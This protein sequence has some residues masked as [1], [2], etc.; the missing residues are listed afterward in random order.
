MAI[1]CIGI[2]KSEVEHL[3]VGVYKYTEKKQMMEKVYIVIQQLLLFYNN[4]QRTHT[5]TKC[6]LILFH[7][8][9]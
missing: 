7:L 2:W 6:R 8:I 3:I 5:W 4:Q 9:L 1:N